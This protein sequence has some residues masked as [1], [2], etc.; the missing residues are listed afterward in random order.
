MLNLRLPILLVACWVVLTATQA[1][2]AADTATELPRVV[3]TTNHG[4]MIAELWPDAAP[5]TVTNFLALASGERAWSD[6]QSGEERAGVP[7]YDGLTFHRVIANFMIQGGC[8]LGNGM[9]SP[10]YTIPDEINATGLGLDREVALE[11][12][13]LHPHCA[14]MQ[15]QITQQLIMPEMQRAG[16]TEATPQPQMQAAWARVL[17]GLEG[18]SLKSLYERLGF[19]YDDTLTPRAL[20]RGVLA[21]ANSGPGTGGSQFFINLVPTPYL[22]GKHTVFGRV[23]E[24]SAVLDAIGQ[25]AVNEQQ[26]HRPI[27]PVTIISIRPAE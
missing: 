11:N 8:P 21:M 19:R 2:H 7:F 3:I 5:V 16:I 24:G 6:P 25:V 14:Y 20:E 12:G 9:G 13:R 22:N 17:S 15:Q 18:I 26:G 1:A 4:V 27:E 23:I 10:G